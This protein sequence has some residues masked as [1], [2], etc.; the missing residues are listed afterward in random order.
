MTRPSV[1]PTYFRAQWVLVGGGLSLRVKWP[2]C[3]ADHFPP[4][5]AEVN[6]WSFTCTPA[7]CLYFMCRDNLRFTLVF[8][9]P[10]AGRTVA[11]HMPLSS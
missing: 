1:E 5:S 4:S 6:E 2:G 7:V 11:I 3:G 8:V 10:P 9:I